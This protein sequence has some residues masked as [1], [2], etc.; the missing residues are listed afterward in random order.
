MRINI[1]P[2]ALRLDNAAKFLDMSSAKFADLVSKN[3]LPPPKSIGGTEE[4][5]LTKD[6]EAILTGNA[7]IPDEEEFEI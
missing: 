2:A 7:A 3:A 4:R 5:W 6:L 1:K